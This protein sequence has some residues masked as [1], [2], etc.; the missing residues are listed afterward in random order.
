M[1]CERI[2]RPK[3]LIAALVAVSVALWVPAAAHAAEREKLASAG[4]LARG[5]GYATTG[6]SDA[7]RTLQQRLRRLGDVPG[8]IDGLYGPLT[9]GAVRRF[10]QR[11]G[12]AADGIVGRQTKRSLFPATAQ[13]TATPAH[14][15]T[16]PGSLTRKTPAP[17][18]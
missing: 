3:L 18:I 8:P 11:R 16:Q 5:S 14:R 7:V 6:G 9:E 15:D 13:P 17:Q 4:L 10:Q 1:A 12:L 2:R